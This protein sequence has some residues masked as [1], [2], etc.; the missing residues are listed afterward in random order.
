MLC[1]TF[2]LY[3]TILNSKPLLELG[4]TGLEESQFKLLRPGGP[5]ASWGTVNIAHNTNSI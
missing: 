4:L 3:W 5:E 2:V 1:Y